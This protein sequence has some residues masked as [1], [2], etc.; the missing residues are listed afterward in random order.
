MVADFIRGLG[1]ASKMFCSGIFRR[2]SRKLRRALPSSEL[3]AIEGDFVLQETLP[4]AKLE[5]GIL[6]IREAETQEDLVMLESQ[7]KRLR[8]SITRRRRSSPSEGDESIVRH[9]EGLLAEIEAQL[10]GSKVDFDDEADISDATTTDISPSAAASMRTLSES[11]GSESG[12]SSRLS[13]LADKA[14][15]SECSRSR[16]SSYTE[17][18]ALSERDM[19]PIKV[20]AEKETWME[21]RRSRADSMV[22]KAD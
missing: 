12:R 3:K 17:K 8:S 6:Y 13:S 11:A 10:K 16:A 1:R 22:F 2:M 21:S 19:S 18:V 9:Y 5:K 20:M 15:P 7:A 4:P 14:G